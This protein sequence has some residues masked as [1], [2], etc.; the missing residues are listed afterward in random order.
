MVP[1]YVSAA[2]AD[3]AIYFRIM[4]STFYKYRFLGPTLGASDPIGH[5]GG[6]DSSACI[7]RK[8]SRWVILAPSQWWG[9]ET[10]G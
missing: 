10:R 7:Y 8:L 4:V 6:M 1:K 2:R 3:G 5:G 9:P